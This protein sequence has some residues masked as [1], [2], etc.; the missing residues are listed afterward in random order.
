MQ[1]N[2]CRVDIYSGSLFHL[3]MYNMHYFCFLCSVLNMLNQPISTF[4]AHIPA[5][6]SLPRLEMPLQST[7]FT[8][9]LFQYSAC[10]N[11]AKKF[12]FPA[13]TSILYLEPFQTCRL[14]LASNER[15][16]VTHV[17]NR[18]KHKHYYGLHLRAYTL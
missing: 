2:A 13:Y 18:P 15:D 10:A 17:G 5:A 14:Y 7:F 1:V 16:A 3:C 12:K 4:D 11:F 9:I 8:S 6:T